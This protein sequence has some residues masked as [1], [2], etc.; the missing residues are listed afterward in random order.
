MMKRIRLYAVH[1]L[2]LVN[3]L[4]SMAWIKL[5]HSAKFDYRENSKVHHFLVSCMWGVAYPV[6]CDREN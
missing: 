5:H 6:Y 2:V 4:Y 3:G 1:V